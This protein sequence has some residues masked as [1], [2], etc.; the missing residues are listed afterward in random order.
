MKILFG[1][2]G[3][4]LSSFGIPSD[5]LAIKQNALQHQYRAAVEKIARG[6][7][8]AGA[9]MPTVNAF[10]LRSL[11]KAGFI[12]LYKEMLSLNLEALLKALGT[13]RERIALCLG[14]ANDCYGPE[15]APDVQEASSFARHQY[16]LCLEV[17]THFGLKL[18]EVV[19]L[20]ETIGTGR[21]A[22]GLSLAARSLQI[23][24]IISFVVNQKGQLLSGET[25]EQVIQQIDSKT[26]GFIEG[27]SLNCCSPYAFEPAIASFKN[28]EH[29]QRL[30]GFYPN[31]YDANP[32][33]YEIGEKLKELKKTESLKR[34]AEAGKQHN[35]RFIGGCC[36]FSP[37]DIQ[38]LV[39]IRSQ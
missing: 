7:V 22:L 36:G 24:L 33:V 26:F 14:P 13:H 12:E 6:Y 20:H 1:P 4:I 29:A 34:I 9:T 37:S 32:C 39:Q 30:I 2:Y 23:P 3:T 21:E 8:Q 10:F 15:L 18:S 17:L 31:S 25:V 16:E 11:L 27:F 5:A 19:F 38:Y 28:I 35:L